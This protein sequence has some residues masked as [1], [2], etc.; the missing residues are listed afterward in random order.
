MGRHAPRGAQLAFIEQA[1]QCVNAECL[2]W[3]YSRSQDGRAFFYEPAARLVCERAHGAAPAGKPEAA[4][5][6]GNGHLGCVNG[7]HLAWK[8]HKDNGADLARHGRVKGERHGNAKLTEVDV[9]AIRASA[10]SHAALAKQYGVVESAIRNIRFYKRWGHVPVLIVALAVSA[11]PA[12]AACHHYSVW[13]YPFVQR[14]PHRAL[15]DKN[16]FVELQ[17]PAAAP[18]VSERT[19]EQE[20]DQRDHDEALTAHKDEIND[21]MKVLKLNERIAGFQG[22]DDK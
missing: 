2:V 21:L 10:S 20:A 14:C 9:Q 22:V 7:S 18:P 12:Q 6:C 11:L 3:P 4:H 8:S 13:L 1:A 17:D 5:L 19:P 15:A 16:W